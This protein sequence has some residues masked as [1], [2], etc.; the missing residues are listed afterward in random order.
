MADLD[1]PVGDV[2]GIGAAAPDI[3]TPRQMNELLEHIGLRFADRRL[4]STTGLNLNE[5]EGGIAADLANRIHDVLL[6][7]GGRRVQDI[8]NNLPIA[9]LTRTDTALHGAIGALIAEVQR[10]AGDNAEKQGNADTLKRNLLSLLL[11]LSELQ[12]RIILQTCPEQAE[13]ECPD[14]VPV[15]NGLI[16]ALGEKIQQLNVVHQARITHPQFVQAEGQAGGATDYY[17][18]KYMKYKMKCEQLK[19]N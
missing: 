14:I 17:K 5:L 6:T 12:A 3:P 19:H 4:E 9:E 15:F 18:Y 1:L 16:E 13:V 2:G 11:Q 10:A 7:I 8:I